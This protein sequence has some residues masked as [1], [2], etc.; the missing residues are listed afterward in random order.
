[1]IDAALHIG[2]SEEEHSPI[3]ARSSDG[4]AGCSAGR[5]REKSAVRTVPVLRY[6][7]ESFVARSLESFTKK[8]DYVFDP[9]CGRGT[10]ILQSLLMDRTGFGTDTNPVAYCI[11]AAKAR[12]P[13]L[14]LILNRI[15]ALEGK[16]ARSD[17]DVFYR[18]K[19]LLPDFFRHAYR[20]STLRSLLFLRTALKWRDDHIDCF[21]AALVLGALH[22]ETDKSNSYLSNQMP[23]TISTK[24]RY[25]IKYWRK[26]GLRA[27]HRDVFELLRRRAR[28]RFST[29][30]PIRKGAVSLADARDSAE[31]FRSLHGRIKAVITSPPYLNVTRYE[32]DQW[33]RLWFLGY[34]AQPTY[35]EMSRDDRHSS[36]DNYWEFLSESWEGVAPLLAKNAVL[37]CRLSGKNISPKELTTNLHESILS[38]F[39]RAHLVRQ[40][41]TSKIRN[42]QTT[43]FRPGSSGC[44]F[45]IDYTFQ[46]T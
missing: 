23:R 4:V 15:D 2:P 34:E 7:P 38:C 12:L 30:V 8:G 14:D 35:S 33:L 22:G 27:P 10:T 18:K 32:E 21:I 43:F 16:L 41:E 3:F 5:Q 6:V 40:P 17:R 20:A 36:Q 13:E 44:S 11:S 28:F 1:M 26:H 19:R 9:F 37:V 45:E 29:G 31:I 25:S 39:P 42:R 24:P 46:L